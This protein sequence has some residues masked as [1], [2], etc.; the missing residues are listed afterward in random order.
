M[1]DRDYRG[2]V[3]V[4]VFN[5]GE[6]E[7]KVERGDRIAQ[8]IVEKIEEVRVR[9]VQVLEETERGEGGYGSTGVKRQK[10]EDGEDKKK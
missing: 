3:G 2:S 1:I 10:V 4:V 7:F 9:E 8:L 5:F 6:E